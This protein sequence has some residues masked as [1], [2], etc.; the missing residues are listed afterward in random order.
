MG[1]KSVTLRSAHSWISL[2]KKSNDW[3]HNMHCHYVLSLLRTPCN[4][5]SSTVLYSLVS[6]R[7]LQDRHLS[8]HF[9]A[10]LHRTQRPVADAANPP[11]D[12][13]RNL[14]KALRLARLPSACWASPT[15]LVALHGFSSAPLL[16]SGHP[17]KL[18]RERGTTISVSEFSKQKT[19]CWIGL[20]K[21]NITSGDSWLKI[22][23]LIPQTG[24]HKLKT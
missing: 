24:S 2:H 18:A 13:E 16:L 1:H 23:V 15:R 14:E 19:S 5:S 17:N 4:H 6:W 20:A 22:G 12:A 10:R 8:T 21:T 9:Y 11:A 3:R 7:W